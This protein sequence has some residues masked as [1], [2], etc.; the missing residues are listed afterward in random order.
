MAV[1]RDGSRL[2]IEVVCSGWEGPDDVADDVSRLLGAVGPTGGD[3]QLDVD[4]DG[5]LRVTL[6]IPLGG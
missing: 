4:G 2:A 3:L 6:Q 1:E 5:R